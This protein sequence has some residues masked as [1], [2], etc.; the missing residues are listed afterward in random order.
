M[1]NRNELLIMATKG[2]EMIEL[3]LSNPPKAAIIM[4]GHYDGQLW[5]LATS[6]NSKRFV[7]CGGDGILRLWDLETYKLV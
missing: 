4:Q 3:I 7:T 5:G 6:P 1:Y 2:G